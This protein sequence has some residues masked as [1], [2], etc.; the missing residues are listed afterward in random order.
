M[1]GHAALRALV[2]LRARLCRASD[3]L[4]DLEG[5]SIGCGCG[6]RR[7]GRID[8]QSVLSHRVAQQL[9]P[10]AVYYAWELGLDATYRLVGGA[11]N[12]AGV[13][14]SNSTARGW[15]RRDAHGEGL[16]PVLSGR[17]RPSAR[18]P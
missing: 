11:G 10:T 13:A 4:G 1:H 5:S 9:T 3:V 2:P 6:R 18:R 7:A 12:D 16:V 17:E 14:V 15:S 8:Q